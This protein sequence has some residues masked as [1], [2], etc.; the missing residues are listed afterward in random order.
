MVIN[1]TV[2]KQLDHVIARVNDAALLHNFFSETLRLPVSWPVKSYKAFTSGGISL[3][4]T[5]L[6]ILS[7]G[8]KSDTLL[9]QAGARFCAFAFECDS[10]ETTVKELGRRRLKCSAVV[11]YIDS[12]DGGPKKH[13]WSNAF[14]DGLVGSD[15]WTRYI[16]FSTKMP[17]YMFWSN[18]L[19]G[20]RIE[21]Q[22]ISRLFGGALV[23]LVEYEYQNFIDMPQWSDFKNHDE[24]RMTDM[25]ALRA[26]GGGGVLGLE[27]VKEIIVG[28][29]DYEK[30]QANW[31]KLFAP[32]EPLAP[33]L[34]EI[35]DGPAVR[36]VQHSED[37]IQA[38]VFKVSDL[39]RA[40]TFL[41]EKDM[42][43]STTDGQIR[44]DAAKIHGL[45]IRLV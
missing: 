10:L 39:A 44:I 45:D 11:P 29:K 3:G 34:W 27:A 32:V 21:R 9:A 35:A 19:R 14:L 37:V 16:I 31:R 8:A 6:E 7:V 20:S 15:F 2:V 38:L 26:Q 13:L 18:L 12:M 30:A 43:G 25:K 24:K 40:E 4:N 1:R 17:G 23:F 33:G 41:R 28:V 42:L 36:L 5:Y 22:G